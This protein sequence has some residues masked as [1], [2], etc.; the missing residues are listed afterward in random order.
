LF[1]SNFLTGENKY[2]PPPTGALGYIFLLLR[3]QKKFVKIAFIS[4]AEKGGICTQKIII[5]DN[6]RGYTFW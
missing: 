4:V 2:T 1:L 5:S 3:D 6:F